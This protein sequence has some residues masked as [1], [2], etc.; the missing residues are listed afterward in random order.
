[1]RRRDEN[2][3]VAAVLGSTCPLASLLQDGVG[4]A[5]VKPGRLDPDH[6][7][8]WKGWEPISDEQLARDFHHGIYMAVVELRR[9]VNEL[10]RLIRDLA[11]APNPQ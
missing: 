1:M 7:P 9:D 2:V 11:E 10:Q 5:Q 3:P 4:V 6:P 8:D